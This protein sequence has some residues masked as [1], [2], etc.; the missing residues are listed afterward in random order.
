[1]T[2]PFREEFLDEVMTMAS[3]NPKELMD[4]EQTF[5]RKFYETSKQEAM[6]SNTLVCPV[7][8][9]AQ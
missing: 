3:M 9:T 6:E 4:N 2:S 1:M 7:Y 8:V 5:I